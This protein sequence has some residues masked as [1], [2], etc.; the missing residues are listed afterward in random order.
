MLEPNFSPF[1]ELKTERLILRQIV[2]SDAPEVLSMRSND[3]AMLYIGKEKTKTI[4]EAESWINV[5][6][7]SLDKNDGITWAIA[8]KDEPGKL[9][10][11][12]GL[13]RLM[14]EH[15][16]AEVGYM[17]HPD[18]WG[19]GITKEA[20][21]AVIRYGFEVM[22]LHS[23]EACIHAENTASAKVLEKTGFTREGY[24]KEDFCFQGKF[25]DSIV[26]SLLVK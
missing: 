3:E 24:F 13:W 16:R 17:L 12:M 23:I 14:K 11:T 26:Y 20:I 22:K 9:I 1:P 5:V 25:T 21:H 4:E 15:Y 18:H 6:Q 19:K 7:D 2:K 10:G 8:F